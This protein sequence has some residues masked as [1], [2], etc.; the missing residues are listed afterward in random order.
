MWACSVSLITVK[1]SKDIDITNKEIME[2]TSDKKE[3]TTKDQTGIKSTIEINQKD[4]T[5]A[6]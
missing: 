1:N 2:Q 6:E 4:T 5:N 3:T